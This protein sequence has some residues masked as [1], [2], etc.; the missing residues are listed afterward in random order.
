MREIGGSIY[1]WYQYGW[2]VGPMISAKIFS[3][4]KTFPNTSAMGQVACKGCLTKVPRLFST[5]V[6]A[7]SRENWCP[8]PFLAPTFPTLISE[9]FFTR[10]LLCSD[11]YT[12]GPQSVA[13]EALQELPKAALQIE[14]IKADYFEICASS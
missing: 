7:T 10:S 12:A 14:L 3:K 6:G 1:P 2:T 4:R 8:P 5:C 13:T 11:D 9:L